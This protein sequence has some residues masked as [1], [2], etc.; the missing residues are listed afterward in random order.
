M[1]AAFS[2]VLFLSKVLAGEARVIR[3]TLLDVELVLITSVS[4]AL[5]SFSMETY[6]RYHFKILLRAANVSH[7]II[8]AIK[9]VSQRPLQ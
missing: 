5:F 4:V 3:F 6:S 8:Q 1:R 2:K 9:A 7:K